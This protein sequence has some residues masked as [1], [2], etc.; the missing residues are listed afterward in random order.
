MNRFIGS[1]RNTFIIA[2]TLLGALPAKGAPSPIDPLLGKYCLACHSTARPTGDIDLENL[3]S[4]RVS[5]ANVRL[6]QKLAE[7]IRLG[8]MPPKGLPR[9][10]EQETTRILDWVD[11]ALR[12]E[13][14]A[15][16]GDPGPVVLRRLN[17]A[18]YTFTIRDLTGVPTLDPAREFPVDG[19]AGEGFTNTGNALGMSPSLV[20]KYLD[21]A[22]QVAKHMVPLPNGIR[23]SRYTSPR[24]WTN[25]TL[26][27]IRSFYRQFTEDGGADTI[28]Q[29]GIALDK[30]RGGRLPLERYLRASL[31]VRQGATV[32][33][34]AAREG[35]SAKYL[36][37]LVTLMSGTSPSPLLEPIRRS[38]LTAK[39]SGIT[40]LVREI[41]VWQETLWKFSSVGHIGKLSGPKAWMEPVSPLQHQQEF[42]LPLR[43]PAAAGADAGNAVRITLAATDAGDGTTGDRVLWQNP[44]LVIPGRQPVALKDVPRLVAALEQRRRLVSGATARALVAASGGEEIG[45]DPVAR[46]AWFDYLGAGAVNEPIKL[47][48]LTRRMERVGEFDF[49]KAWGGGKE[50]WVVANPSSRAVRIPGAMKPQGVAL[51]PTASQQAAVGWQS[52][53]TGAITIEATVAAAHSEC[54]NGVSWAV[55]LRRGGMRLRLGDGLTRRATPSGLAATTL[56]VRQ[57]DLISVLIGAREGNA[58][59]DLTSLDWTIRGEGGQWSLSG[60]TV[61]NLLAANPHA[62]TNGRAGVWHF[63]QEPDSPAATAVPAGSLL[64]RWVTAATDDSRRALATQMQHLLTAAPPAADTPDG[65]LYRQ[66]TSLAGPLL[67]GVQ[68]DPDS[69]AANSPW[70][71]DPKRFAGQDLLLDAPGMLDFQLPADLV[72]AAEFAVTGTLAPGPASAQGSVQL[73]VTSGKPLLAPGLMAGATTV[74][75]KDGTWSNNNQVLSM[76][77]P[78]VT[79]PGTPAHRRF[80]NAFDEFR[81]HFPASLCYTKI[82]PVD[83]VVTMTLFH[84]ED[85]HLKRLLLNP[86]QQ[87][88]IDRLWEELHFLSRSPLLMVDAFEQLWQY[89][90]QDADPSQFEPLRQPIQRRAMEFRQALVAAESKQLEGVIEFAGRA[91]RR[92]LNAGARDSLT[93]LYQRLRAQDL[94]HDEALR[95]TLGRVLTGPEFLYRSETAP[96]GAAPG[97]LS[98]WDLASRLSYFLWSSQPDATLREA[99]ASGRLRTA[100]GRTAEV[101][102]MLRDGRVRRLASEFGAAWLHIQGF[103]T[104]DEKSERHFPEFVA[105]RADM[106]EE[107]LR[108]LTDFFQSGRSV[109]SLLDADHTF[110]NENLAKHYGIAGVQG[111]DWRRVEGL[112]TLSR[113]G[114]LGHSTTLAKQSGASRTS[115]ILRGNW[116]SEVLLGDKLPRPPK[117]VPQLPD[118]EA[119]LTLTMRELTEKHTSDPRCYS[120]HRRIDPYGYTLERFDAIGRWREK[121][122]GGRPIH[123]RSKLLDGTEVDG[124]DG[125]RQ[126]LLGPRR[127]AFL[128]QFCRKL[129]GYALGRAVQLS[130]EPLLDQMQSRMAAEGYSVRAAIETIVNS[131][132][133]RYIRGRDAAAE[134]ETTP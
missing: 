43:P 30:S 116:I 103:D 105:L 118:D 132:Q 47:S 8:E 57:G 127:S 12:A 128:R 80:E 65:I 1:A 55:E 112:R 124:L 29:Q 125:L 41:G 114:I 44:R 5:A 72:N 63:Y 98:S 22:K 53:V 60:D 45:L 51:L 20:S 89:A 79:A 129:L 119:N 17:N 92:P 102:R 56:P 24:D 15:H 50:P 101:R 21:A 71:L 133:F 115:P 67:A 68:A 88:Q 75:T 33:A 97:P 69:T 121:D 109:L 131:R 23:F 2:V 130:D 117:D 13:A 16:A 28:R 31:R 94:P 123:T 19:A 52:P 38:W 70:G 100:A 4:R 49:V 10:T 99:A 82:V 95:L 34:V 74:T 54:G 62:D 40:G 85:D 106:F 90:T 36:R 81:R 86:A 108:F 73:Q 7:Q 96:A 113:G 14:V 48:L 61:A 64:A 84:R 76:T 9:P 35:L 11:S 122:L 58:A 59:C 3:I 87:K 126:Y 107:T 6:W 77:M 46:K 66:L 27:E 37:T 83:E 120:C 78:V 25:E 91:Y 26:D 18:E 110:V 32:E 134:E 39:P 93:G 111:P 42:R 104:L